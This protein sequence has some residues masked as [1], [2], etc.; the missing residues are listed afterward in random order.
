MALVVACLTDR[1]LSRYRNLAEAMA[2]GIGRCGD[3][4][5]LREVHLPP[6]EAD[7]AV[8]Y[9]WKKRA[10]FAPYRQFVYADL[11]FWQR[12]RFHRLSVNGWSPAGYVRAGLPVERFAALGLEVKPWRA[13]G[14]EIVIA[15]STAKAAADH[16]MGYMEWE[17]RTAARLAGCGRPIVYRPKP[18]D[19]GARPIEGIAFDT[20]PIGEALATAW[21]WVTHHSNSAIDAL[22]AGVPAHCETGAGAAFSVPLDEIAEPPLMEGRG[23]F[24][25]DV[26]WLQ[27]THDEMRSGACWAHLKERGLVC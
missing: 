3:R 10:L 18:N 4:A 19:R 21:A 12:D 25:A 9:G 20:R 2:E 11:G 22:L 1:R 14:R 13:T 16:G 15:G 6:I 23:Q 24:L 8:M 7:C 26:A 27:W 5:V 17:R